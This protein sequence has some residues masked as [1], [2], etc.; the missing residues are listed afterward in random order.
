[1]VPGSCENAQCWS[2]ASGGQMP[3]YQFVNPRLPAENKNP[4]L[5]PEAQDKNGWDDEV[6][7]S[8]RNTIFEEKSHRIQN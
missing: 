3:L 6:L 7:G 2:G 1:M 5:R 8:Q 4:A